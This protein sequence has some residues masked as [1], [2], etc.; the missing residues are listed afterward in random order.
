M[1]CQACGVTSL[2]TLAAGMSPRGTSSSAFLLHVAA[3]ANASVTLG[4]SLKTAHELPP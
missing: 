1:N 4:Q 3:K 2:S